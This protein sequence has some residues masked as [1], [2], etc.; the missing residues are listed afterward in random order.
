M[1]T[2]IQATLLRHLREN[3]LPQG[4][5]LRI[6]PGDDLFNSGILDSAAVIS[7]ILFIEEDFAITIP[8]EDLLPENLA[9][10]DAAVA[11]ITR[12]LDGARTGVP[13]GVEFHG[14]SEE[15]PRLGPR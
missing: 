1:T 4:G 2:D 13:N 15:V 8:D 14:V 7:V 11:Y 6:D 5:D 3:Y 9:S 10:V 12:R